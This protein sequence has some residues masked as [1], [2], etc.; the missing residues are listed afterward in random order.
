[1]LTPT[2]SL[3]SKSQGKRTELFVKDLS[4]FGKPL[5]EVILVD[6]SSCSFALQPCNGIPIIGF[7]GE[8]NDNQLEELQH[9]LLELKDC[10][11]VRLGIKKHFSFLHTE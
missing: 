1:M 11:D 7:Q 9:L 4:I 3:I 10:E 8:K 2:Q 5:N 6:N